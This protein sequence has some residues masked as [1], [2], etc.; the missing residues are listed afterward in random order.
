MER[1]LKK[2][3]GT[4]LCGQ[5]P[6]HTHTHNEFNKI[7][8]NIEPKWMKAFNLCQSLLQN[9]HCNIYPANFGTFTIF[10][11]STYKKNRALKTAIRSKRWQRNAHKK[12][13]NRR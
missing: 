5:K 4:I 12:Q 11:D 13:H 3:F 6:T 2:K 7:S 9:L 10:D 8:K 1:N